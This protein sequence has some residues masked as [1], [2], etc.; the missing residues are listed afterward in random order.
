MENWSLITY[1]CAVTMLIIAYLLGSI[2]SAVW[3]GKKYYGIDIREY[4]SKN[5]GTTNMLRVLGRRAAL[6][7]FVLDFFK[8]FIAVSLIGIMRYDIDITSAW[9]I[10]LKIMGV[11]AAVLGHIFPIFAGFKGGKGVAT[12]VGAITGIYPIV[13]LLCFAVWVLV[14]L[15]THY[16]SLA[17][18]TAGCSF[19]I[20]AIIY[21]S[22]EW[23]RVKDVSMSFIVFSFVVAGLLLWSHR[24]NIERLKAGTESKI[25]VWRPHDSTAAKGPAEGGDGNAAGHDTDKTAGNR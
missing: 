14:F 4:G 17:S 7:V 3:I 18:M 20:F 23:S 21:S 10:N 13:V 1:Y 22:M 9:L 2:P 24:K 19:P 8:G 15:I 6:P 5:A 12:L 16:V 11:F 25:Y